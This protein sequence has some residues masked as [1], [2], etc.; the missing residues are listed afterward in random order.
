MINDYEK[1]LANRERH[2]GLLF[3][4]SAAL[5]QSAEVQHRHELQGSTEHSQFGQEIAG[6]IFDLAVEVRKNC[7][8][9]AHLCSHYHS[10]CMMRKA[11]DVHIVNEEGDF[12]PFEKELLKDS[13]NLEALKDY[14]AIKPA[15]SDNRT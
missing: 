3:A 7:T 5:E 11:A 1:G 9:I 14:T 15:V 12:K 10:I 13:V 8:H 4:L 6:E 2:L